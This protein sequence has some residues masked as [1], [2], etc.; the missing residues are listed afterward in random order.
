MT[1]LYRERLK[2][3]HEELSAAE[4]GEESLLFAISYTYLRL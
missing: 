2:Q 4:Q 3:L 1:S